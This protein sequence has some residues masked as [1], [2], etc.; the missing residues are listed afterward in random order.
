M[1]RKASQS[2]VVFNP[3]GKITNRVPQ[4]HAPLRAAKPKLSEVKQEIAWRQWFPDIPL[5]PEGNMPEDVDTLVH[6]FTLFCEEN[7]YIKHPSKGRIA[8]KLRD[9]QKSVVRDW[10][11]CRYTVALKARQIGFSTLAAAY[12]LWLCQW[13]DRFIVMLSRTE[14]EAVK[15]LRKVRYNWRSMPDWVRERFPQLLDNNQTKMTFDNES[16]IESL[17]SNNDPARGESVF[18]VVVDEWGFLPNA[19]EAW[20]SI[21]PVAD[22]GGR[23]IGIGTANGEGNFYHQLWLD[24]QSG[25]NQFRGI[26]HSWRAVPERDDEWYAQ[27]K[28]QHH[29]QPWILYQEYPSNP[30][31]A[32]QGSGNP[33]YNLE[34][35]RAMAV[36]KP[37]GDY[38]ITCGKDGWRKPMMF[39]GGPFEVF[40]T[41]SENLTY[42]LGVDVAE[43]LEHGD[44]SVVWVL[45][46][47]TGDPVAV[48]RGKCE[49]DVFGEEIVPAIGGYYNTA[50]I[51]PE[52]NNHGISVLKAL[53]RAKY[54]R[55]YR[56]RSFTKRIDTI[57]GQTMGWMTTHTSKPLLVDELGAWLRDHSV[58]HRTTLAELKTFIRDERG[59]MHGSPHDDTVMALGIAV[60]CRK[61]TV[62]RAPEEK[63]PEEVEGSI[64]WW[65]RQLNKAR[66]K[67][68]L[69]PAMR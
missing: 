65:S 28:R 21:E 54:P 43:G 19:E 14:R 29:M 9:A 41:P 13:D 69:T 42:C 50:M 31:E 33:V 5:L 38:T 40:A 66:R 32:F 26:F 20:A 46:V 24:S 25:E 1:P 48:W 63:A 23:V 37:L 52:V 8:F 61:Y 2:R 36:Q 58:P 47:G 68:G 27:K 12:V 18:L 44:Y 10:M 17:P 57:Q 34:V 51:A 16:S 55:M 15:L 22:I 7:F 30:E 56:R 35:L 64:A 39:E 45:E 60:Q 11:E 3:S 53:Q 62:E 6:A 49:P 67:G 59:R 4:N